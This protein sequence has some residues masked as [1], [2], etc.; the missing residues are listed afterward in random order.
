MEENSVTR[1][2]QRVR[3]ELKRRE[4]TVARVEMLAPEYA[5]ITFQGDALQDFVSSSFDDHVKF[6]FGDDGGEPVRRD[7]TPRYYDRAARQLTVE[8][9]LHGQGYASDWAR[10]AA[11]G[12]PVVIGGPRGSMIVPVDFAWHVLAGD[13]TAFPAIRRRL[14]E[15]PSTAR[16][17]VLVA[18]ETA[19]V[20]E[21][22]SQAQVQVQRLAGDAELVEAIRT[23][24]FPQGEG[25][26]WCAGEAA[27]AAQVR[28]ILQQKNFP[29][30]ASR[31]S[32]YWKKGA[33]DHHENL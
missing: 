7:Y 21:L 6:M 19:D 10:Q 2:I 24:Q 15:L 1:R 17:F 12:Q 30:E 11:P 4:V 23:L 31:V 20:I 29:R 28:E 13:A 18:G 3:H 22:N 5:S 8:F 25:F 32:A 14:E 33:A 26:V 9:A 27:M 16:V